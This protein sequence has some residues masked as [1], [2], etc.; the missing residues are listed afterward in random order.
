[1][2]KIV[3][4]G[5]GKNFLKS[6]ARK[7]KNPPIVSYSIKRGSGGKGPAGGGVEGRGQIRAPRRGSGVSSVSSFQEG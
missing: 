5:K 1:M 6:S 2:G 7:K 4:R 3:K